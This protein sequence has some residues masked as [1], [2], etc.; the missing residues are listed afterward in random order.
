VTGTDRKVGVNNGTQESRI[1][2]D[3]A[4]AYRQRVQRVEGDSS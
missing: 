4:G 3:N 1:R 2:G